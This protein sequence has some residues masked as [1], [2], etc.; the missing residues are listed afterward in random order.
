MYGRFF[1]TSTPGLQVLSANSTYVFGVYVAGAQGFH[2]AV[3]SANAD[4]PR[5]LTVTAR[6]IGPNSVAVFIHN[7]TSVSIT[8]PAAQWQ[9][10]TLA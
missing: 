10:T 8:M 2:T 6:V 1:G 3:V 9:V 7:P 4:I 5:G